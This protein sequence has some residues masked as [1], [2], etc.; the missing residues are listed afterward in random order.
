MK[1]KSFDIILLSVTALFLVG[2]GVGIFL[3][4]EDSFSEEENRM[5]STFKIPTFESVADGRASKNI[6]DASRDRLPLRLGFLAMRSYTELLLGKRECNG[7]IFA[8]DGYLLARGEYDSL[9]KAEQNLSYL[10]L[11]SRLCREQNK[12]CTSAIAPRGIDVMYSKLPPM[13]S[14]GED[15]IWRLLECSEVRHIDLSAPLRNAADRGEQVWYKTD[16]HWTTSGAYIAYTEL[17]SS[18]GYTPHPESFFQRQTVSEDFLGTAYSRAGCI[19][20]EADSIELYR[21]EGDTELIL[22]LPKGGTTHKGLYYEER[23]SQKDKYLVFLGGNYSELSVK[24]PKGEGRERLLIIKDSYANSLVPFLALHY[25]IELVDLRYFAGGEAAL[26]ERIA[27]ADR[28]L[29]LHGIDTLATTPL[30]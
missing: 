29:L 15:R 6:S 20:P 22:E 21:Y 30:Y 28:V 10:C 14:G 16:H 26:C 12:P 27:R 19:S 24:A 5:L 4:S 3:P 11:L 9:R 8:R 25:D 1:K 18:L 13:Y 23:L 7:V 17:S 2:F